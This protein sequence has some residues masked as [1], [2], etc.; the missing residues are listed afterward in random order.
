MIKLNISWNWLYK[1]GFEYKDVK[2]D[3]FIEEYKWLDMI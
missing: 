1:L 3:V 2:K